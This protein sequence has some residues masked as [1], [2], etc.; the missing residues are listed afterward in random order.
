VLTTIKYDLKI[1]K[2]HQKSLEIKGQFSNRLETSGI[3]SACR[4]GQMGQIIS[5][6]SADLM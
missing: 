3:V 1:F 2:L 5:S 6:N 4:G